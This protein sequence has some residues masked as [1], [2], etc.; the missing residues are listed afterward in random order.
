MHGLPESIDYVYPTRLGKP[1]RTQVMKLTYSI[2]LLT[3][4]TTLLLPS[5]SHAGAESGAYIGAGIG[6]SNI[7]G[8]VNGE[9]YDADSNGYKLILGYNFGVVPLVDLAIE[10]TYVDMGEESSGNIQY[11]QTSFNGFGLLGLSL[12]PVGLFAKAGLS[13]WD[14]DTS[15]GNLKTSQSGSD[16]VYGIGARVQ[17]FRVSGRL[18]YEYYDQS[19]LDDVSMVSLSLLYTF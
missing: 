16:P 10:G 9:S 17:I 15:I 8:P 6:N 3:L 18:E 13:A 11:A 12:G 19:N 5:V 4:T 14:A 7:K 1:G 2:I